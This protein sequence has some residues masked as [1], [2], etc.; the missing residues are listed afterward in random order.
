MQLEAELIRRD[1]LHDLFCIV[2]LRDMLANRIV[3]GENEGVQTMA[4]R[5]H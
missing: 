3:S 1:L 5:D 2:T 4:T